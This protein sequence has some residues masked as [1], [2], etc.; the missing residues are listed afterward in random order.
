MLPKLCHGLSE[1]ENR[2]RDFDFGLTKYSVTEN[3]VR[4]SLPKFTIDIGLGLQPALE[5]VSKIIYM[6]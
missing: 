2:I 3:I 4:V 1:L 5:G 6:H